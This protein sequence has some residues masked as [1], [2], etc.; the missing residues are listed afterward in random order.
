M[1]K[2][3]IHTNKKLYSDYSYDLQFSRQ[4]FLK[5]VRRYILS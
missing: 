1:L 2:M 5:N 4:E 3:L